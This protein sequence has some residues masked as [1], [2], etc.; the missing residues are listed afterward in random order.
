MN[1]MG[2]IVECDILL[3][4]VCTLFRLRDGARA[5]LGGGRRG[6]HVRT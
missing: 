5:A 6:G 3:G 4:V 2:G 1:I